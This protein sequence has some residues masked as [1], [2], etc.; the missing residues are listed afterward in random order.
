[1]ADS[2]NTEDCPLGKTANASFQS[3]HDTKTLPYAFEIKSGGRT[4]HHMRV[5]LADDHDLVRDAIEALLKADEATLEVVSVND[6][7]SALMQVQGAGGFDAIVLDLHMPGMNG[8]VGARKMLNLAEDTPVLLMSG[9]ASHLEV[10]T[11]LKMGIRGFLPK[12]LAGKSLM[13]ALRLVMSGETFV[14]AEY[15]FDNMHG[16]K[17]LPISLTDREAEV[18]WQLRQGNSN[19]D[20]S[21]VL[22]IPETKVKSHLKNL[23][24]KLNARNRTDIVVRAISLGMA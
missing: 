22:E 18:L 16:A 12:T 3:I 8:L 21:L 9:I 24:A 13:S 4:P 6:L 15:L 17:A 20:I 10:Q 2:K 7:P 19:K 23:S 5:L 14:P 1:M 11:G